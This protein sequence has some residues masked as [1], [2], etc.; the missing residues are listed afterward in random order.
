MAGHWKKGKKAG[1][2]FKRPRESKRSVPVGSELI[3]RGVVHIKIA[4]NK[5][6]PKHRYLWEQANGPL[7]KGSIIIFANND[8]RD[9]SPENLIC[10]TRRELA[11]MNK[12]K[13]NTDLPETK[14]AAILLSKIGLKRSELQRG[15]DN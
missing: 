8:K 15:L 5:W 1:I 13:Y 12:Q 11:Y 2:D 4:R 3:N 14:E 7:P 6:V 9:F 10:I